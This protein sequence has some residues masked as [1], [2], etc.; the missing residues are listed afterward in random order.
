[1]EGQDWRDSYLWTIEFDAFFKTNIKAI[2]K[3]IFALSTHPHKKFI[4]LDDAKRLLQIC[5]NLHGLSY[6]MIK[7]AFS[8]SKELHIKEM[9]EIDKYTKLTHT[10]FLEFLAR[11]AHLLFIDK[12]HLSIIEKTELVLGELLKSVSEKVKHPP[13]TEDDELISDFEDDIVQVARKKMRE[14]NHE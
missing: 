1:M 14:A 5:S 11:I 8:H 9:E 13:R 7:I 6:E 2:N 10:E 3:V 12:P 4:M